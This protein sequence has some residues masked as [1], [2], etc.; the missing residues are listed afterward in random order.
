MIPNFRK[1]IPFLFLC[2][3][4]M[5]LMPHSVSARE[6]MILSPG[7]E[8]LAA[9]TTMIKSGLIC[10]DVCFDREDFDRSVGCTVDSITI[11]AL[12]PQSSG[13]LFVGSTPAAVNQSVSAANLNYLRFVPSDTCLESTF[14][15]KSAGEY[16]MEC[17]IRFLTSVNFAPSTD[18]TAVPVSLWTQQDISTYGSLSAKDPE[19]DRLMFEITKQ[20]ESGLL[21]LTNPSA[22]DYKYTPYDGFTGSDAFTYTVRDEY[23]H[24]SDE[25]T[26]RV[27]VEKTV[28]ELVFADMNEHW[29]HNAALV[30]VS[31]NAMDVI[32]S[33]GK[34]YFRPDEHMTRED[35][36]VTVMKALGAGEIPACETA[37]ADNAAISSENRGYV[38]RA[39]Q[40]GIV[41]GVS[42]GGKLYFRPDSEITRAEAAVILNSILGVDT[43]A[44]APVFADHSDV[45]VWA[46]SSLYALN[47][48]GIL[49][50]TGSG[51]LSPS[52]SMSRAQTAQLLLTVKKLYDN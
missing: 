14:R 42:D 40:L 47:S 17:S 37:F 27:N 34:I 32:S 16:S 23:G 8:N 26:V 2:I 46:Q 21:I 51:Y 43:P 1:H 38:D 49:N 31:C 45:P 6:T 4:A 50:G 10:T 30:M 41:R 29:A 9:E 20:P 19:G 25:K 33:D 22:G 36:L 11:T 15:F 52:S 35:F 24:Y 48:A 28:T 39:F 13:T 5:F 3:S 7:L 12:P 44:A 18:E